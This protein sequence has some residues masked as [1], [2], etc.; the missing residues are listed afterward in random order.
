MGPTKTG[1]GDEA[2]AT[3][4]SIDRVCELSPGAKGVIVDSILRGTHQQ[5]L[6]ARGLITVNYPHAKKNPD[7][8]DKGRNSESRVGKQHKVRTHRHK[9]ANGRDCQHDIW[10]KDSVFYES[11][12]DCDGNLVEV[13]VYVVG[14]DKR[15]N[16]KVRNQAP[17]TRFYLRLQLNCNYGGV[18]EVTIPYLHDDKSTGGI[19]GFNR[20]E[21][22]R[23]YPTNTIHFRLL[24]GRRNDTESLHNQIK[25]YLKKMPAY[26]A[27]KQLLYVLG[28]SITHNATTRAHALRAAGIDNPL[29]GTS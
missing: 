11:Q 26:G 6:A 3:L 4:K 24:Y 18:Q 21:Y 10:V 5:Q 7:R 22:I 8:E 14:Y 1:V 16:R 28:L 15:L 19:Q 25:R 27:R 9:L 20:G 13:E 12:Y 17:E 23:F 29:D 2:A